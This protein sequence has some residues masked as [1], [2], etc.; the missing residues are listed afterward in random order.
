MTS[1]SIVQYFILCAQETTTNWFKKTDSHRILSKVILSTNKVVLHSDL[2]EQVL[3]DNSLITCYVD[4]HTILPVFILHRLFCCKADEQRGHT[5]SLRIHIL[6][7]PLH[8]YKSLA[9][10]R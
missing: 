5:A 4:Y 3:A 9:C 1:P 7:C 6:H 8:I 2:F 10:D